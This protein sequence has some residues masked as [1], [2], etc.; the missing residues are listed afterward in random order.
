[1]P[2]NFPKT[3]HMTE[4]MAKVTPADLAA[5][6]EA[7][8]APTAELSARCIRVDDMADELRVAL[9]VIEAARPAVEAAELVAQRPQLGD[10]GVELGRPAAD[11]LDHE[12]TGGLALLARGRG[13]GRPP[14]VVTPGGRPVSSCS[15]RV[16][17][18]GPMA[19]TTRIPKA[20]LTSI[21]GAL[22]Q[23]MNR[24]MFGEVPEPVEVAWHNRKV[25]SLSFAIGRKS[26]KWG[27]QPRRLQLLPRRRLLPR[28][29]QG[30]RRGQG[31]RRPPVA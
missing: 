24:K 13:R 18:G 8:E 27:G 5:R 26:Q 9:A 20:Q 6:L 29:R 3:G 25:L 16:P 17:R 21:Y 31:P 12:V 7:R 19:S 23:R 4:Q 11:Q 14:E 28:A 1:M 10:A 30:S 15:E 22:V 2:V